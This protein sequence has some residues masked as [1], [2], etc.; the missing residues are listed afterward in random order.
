MIKTML[1]CI[2]AAVSVMAF[3]AVW[4]STIGSEVALEVTTEHG[5]EDVDLPVIGLWAIAMAAC[6]VIWRRM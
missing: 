5:V 6:L 3:Y 2:V 1:L 4:G